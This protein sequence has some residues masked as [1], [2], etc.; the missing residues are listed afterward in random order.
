MS[1]PY[2]GIIVPAAGTGVSRA[3]FGLPVQAAIND[4]DARLTLEEAASVS[5]DGRLDALEPFS[6]WAT[7]AMAWT[8]SGGNPAVGNAVV[9]SRYRRQGKLITVNVRVT[10]GSTTTYGSGG[11]TMSLPVAAAQVAVGS[12]YLRDTSAA[13]S[14]HFTGICVVDPAL[15]ASGVNFFNVNVQVQPTTPF[16]WTNTDHLSFTIS[17]ETS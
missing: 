15:N 16:T 1:G 4:I 11:W 10:M 13:A 6:E 7:Y 17:Y 8:G 14:G 3:G 5:L 9:V 12:A 2:T